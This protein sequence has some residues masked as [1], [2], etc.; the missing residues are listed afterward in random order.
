MKFYFAKTTIAT[1]LR[2]HPKQLQLQQ[3]KHRGGPVQNFGTSQSWHILSKAAS[4]Q[5]AATTAESFEQLNDSQIT[6]KKVRRHFF[7]SM[8]SVK[9]QVNLNLIYSIQEK[10]KCFMKRA[11]LVKTK[12]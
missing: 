4:S 9:R 6:N 3:Q 5:Q 2:R 10:Q 1:S 7:R 12:Y 8:S 11:A